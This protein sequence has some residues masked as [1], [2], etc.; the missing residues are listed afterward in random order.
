MV[1]LGDR[2]DDEWLRMNTSLTKLV[3]GCVKASAKARDLLLATPQHVTPFCALLHPSLSGLFMIYNPERSQ[4]DL[5]YLVNSGEVISVLSY[6]FRT[7]YY[8]R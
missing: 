6:L 7:T 5:I 1:A 2:H 4:R 3:R 8:S